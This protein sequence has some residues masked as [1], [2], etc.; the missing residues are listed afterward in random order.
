MKKVLMFL[1]L[2]V[3]LGLLAGCDKVVDEWKFSEIE[4]TIL[5]ATVSIKDGEKL[6]GLLVISAEDYNLNIKSDN[7]LVFGSGDDAVTGTWVNED[8][9]Y[10]LTIDGINHNARVVDDQLHLE[11]K[12]GTF[13]VVIKYV[14]A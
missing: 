2:I 5:G 6:G 10:T 13:E 11:Y 1:L 7:T 14:K 9:V 4:T 3:T 8:G 12:I